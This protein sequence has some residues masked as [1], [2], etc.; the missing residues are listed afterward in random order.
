[1]KSLP[2][3]PLIEGD[4]GLPTIRLYVSGAHDAGSPIT[5]C[6]MTGDVLGTKLVSPL[7]VAKIVVAPTGN[8][9]VDSVATPL[10][11][12]VP[13]PRFVP[14]VAGV[15]VKNVTVPVGVP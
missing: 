4:D 10:P 3:V 7:Y 15:P 11:L 9:E 6:V 2:L 13:L 8:V 12:S 14:G 5:F 1:M